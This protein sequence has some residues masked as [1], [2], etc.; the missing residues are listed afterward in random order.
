MEKYSPEKLS[1][2]LEEV[3]GGKVLI[4][5]AKHNYVGGKIPPNPDKATCPK[6][7]EAYYV[8]DYAMQ[9]PWKR[10]ER[11]EELDEVV[12]HAVEF[13]QKGTFGNDLELYEPGDPRFQID[14]Q[15]DGE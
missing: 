14:Y 1:R 4:N 10:Q 7:W 15:K 12:H 13:A 3:R 8:W 6:C 2:L 5:C 9:L 11:L